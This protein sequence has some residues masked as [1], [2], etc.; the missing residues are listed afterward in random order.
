MRELWLKPYSGK[1]RQITVFRT[2]ITLGNGSGCD[3]QLNDPYVSPTHAELRLE[4][5][6]HG[7]AVHDLSS[8]NGVF[9]NGVRVKVA[10]LPSSGSLRLGRSVFSWGETDSDIEILDG[11]LVIADPSMRALVE[12][13]KRIAASNLPVLLLGETGTGKDVIAK[14]LHHWGSS[15]SGPFVPVNGALTGGTLAESELFGHRKGAF[16][17]AEIPRLGAL[18]SANGG[19]LFLDEVA[20]VPSL[21]QV[22]LLR[23]LESGEVKALGSDL[24]DR[25]DFRLVTATSRN[26]DRKIREGSFRNDLYYRI[27]GFVIHVPPLRERPKDISAIALRL[28]HDR[29]MELDSETERLLLQYP[30][31]GNVR[32][33]RA[34]VERAVVSARAG[35]VSCLLPEHL[36]GMEKNV[37]STPV[38]GEWTPRTLEEIERE[39]M[40]A[41]LKRHGWS[42]TQAAKE[43]GIARSTLWE[44]MKRYG[45]QG[46]TTGTPNS[47]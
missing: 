37:S 14:M 8:R 31:P 19:T 23:A 21:T 41:T 24:C 27:A 44:K 45:L 4:A 13:V 22:K 2:Q 38:D 12:S 26:I 16:T 34:C 32:E 17:G 11:G 1:R 43:L 42:R 46:S 33:L 40:A 9:L 36:V 18:R 6:G 35:G 29:K 15:S 30:W 3:I 7:Y 20:D 28:A 5:G 39:S 10:P 25:S 47:E